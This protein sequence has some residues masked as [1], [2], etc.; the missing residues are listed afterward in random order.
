MIEA[1]IAAFQRAVPVSDS[2]R[3]EVQDCMMDGQLYDDGKTI[4]LSTRLVRLPQPQRYFIMAHEFAHHRLAH[5]ARIGTVP[6]HIVNQQARVIPP[7]D[8]TDIDAADLAHRREFE[9][10][11]Y[12]VRM[13]HAQGLDPEEAARLFD[14]MGASKDS[15]THPSFGRRARAIRDVIATLNEGLS[16]QARDIRN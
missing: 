14:G 15:A 5:H 1:D 8:V 2:A 6:A 3:F 9:A 16:P 4:V 11:A 7:G 10:D 13:M 12:A